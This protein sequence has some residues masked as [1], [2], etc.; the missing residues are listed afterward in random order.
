MKRILSAAMSICMML[1]LFTVGANAATP[2]PSSVVVSPQSLMVDGAVKDVQKYNIDGSNYFKLRDLAYL[3]NGTGSQ[4]G[5]GWDADAG[6][7]S[8][9]TGEAYTPNGSEMQTGKDESA[10]TVASAQAIKIDGKTRSDLYVYNIGGANFFKLRDLGTALGFEVDY[11]AANNA[12]TVATKGS[13]PAA[14]SSAPAA[15][16]EVTTM[17]ILGLPK[18]IHHIANPTRRGEYVTNILYAAATGNYDFAYSGYIGTP[19]EMRLIKD[20]FPELFGAWPYGDDLRILNVDNT[21]R[22]DAQG[23]TKAEAAKH[24][25]DAI[26]AAKRIYSQLH[27]SGKVTDGM[28]Q[29]QIAQVYYDYINDP[30]IGKKELDES[31]TGRAAVFNMMMHME[32]IPAVSLRTSVQGYGHYMH[33]LL[34]DGKEYICDLRNKQFPIRA[35]SDTIGSFEKNFT[36]FDKELAAARAITK[37]YAEKSLSAFTAAVEGVYF[38]GNYYTGTDSERYTLKTVSGNMT[39]EY[40]GD[41]QYKFTP[42][43]G[44]KFTYVE[45]ADFHYKYE[46]GDAKGGIGGST[47]SIGMIIEDGSIIMSHAEGRA[48]ETKKN[49][50]RETAALKDHGKFTITYNGVTYKCTTQG[51]K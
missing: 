5:V 32:G 6:V 36:L 16:G 15:R 39:V 9:T 41:Y 38:G 44:G 11:D 46:T 1:S 51:I 26:N 33:Y 34:L 3:L 20:N 25:T 22:L 23:I 31:I 19:I 30:G 8:I 12:A 45:G 14:Q 7:V 28:T 35:A 27:A 43:D 50:D 18:D 24:T 13:A 21:Y 37:A 2:A 42:T 40:L 17:E 49:M 47:N 10:S 29:L 4:F 48:D